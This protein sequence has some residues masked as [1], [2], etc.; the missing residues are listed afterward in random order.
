MTKILIPKIIDKLEL[1]EDCW[2]AGGAPLTFILGKPLTRQQ[3][4]DIF[5]NSEQAML[6]HMKR[7]SAKYGVLS[8]DAY[9]GKTFTAYHNYY[10]IKYKLNMIAF[11]YRPSPEETL[12]TFDL[13]VAQIAIDH[14]GTFIYGGKTL[15]DVSNKEMN[16]VNFEDTFASRV[17]WLMDNQDMNEKTANKN[18]WQFIKL[19]L[20]KYTDKG[21]TPG[22]TVAEQMLAFE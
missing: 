14:E 20:A 8:E 3:D 4:I 12:D 7:L 21:F 11:K 2:I 10:L 22:W 19:R 15:E 18:A 17:D 1:N 6:E 16:F 13:T 9:N 5:Y